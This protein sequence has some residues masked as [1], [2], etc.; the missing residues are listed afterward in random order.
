VWF[1]EALPPDA[2]EAAFRAAQLSDVFFCAYGIDGR[3]PAAQ[4][5]FEALRSGEGGDRDQ[6]LPTP[7][8]ER[9]T[10]VLEG[11]A[12][13]APEVGAYDLALSPVRGNSN[14]G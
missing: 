11:R 3:V 5:P 7:L 10:F 8:T 9:A 12:E 13:G 4:L 6:P 14:S 2:L 1:G